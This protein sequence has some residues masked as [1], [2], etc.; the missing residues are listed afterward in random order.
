ML[1]TCFSLIFNHRKFD[2][3]S[4]SHT[5]IDKQKRHLVNYCKIMK[6]I[7]KLEEF[8]TFQINLYI[9]LIKKFPIFIN[10]VYSKS[11]IT[12]AELIKSERIIN[13]TLIFFKLVPLAFSTFIPVNFLLV[14]APLKLL[15]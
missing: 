8:G 13:E 1:K 4:S 15:F 12:E 10:K 3:H 9:L 7:Q 6:L 2:D 5:M 11:I 14:K